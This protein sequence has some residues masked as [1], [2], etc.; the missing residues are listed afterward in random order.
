MH[1]YVYLRTDPARVDDVLVELA[2]KHGVR[3][4]VSVTGDWDI[5]VAVEGADFASVGRTTKREVLTVDGVRR[6]TTAPVVPLELLGVAGEVAMGYPLYRDDPC[7][8]VHIDTRAGAVASVA[9]ILLR[10]RD[11]SGIAVLAGRHDL[12]VEIPLPWEAASRVILQEL[13]GIEGIVST[14]TSVAIAPEESD[15]D[16]IH[17]S[18]WA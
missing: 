2:G 18:S 16:G 7:C 8:Y 3:N 11:V 5:L 4:A 13:H 10:I 12:L 1:A 15:E 9:E 14:T 17:P 6:S